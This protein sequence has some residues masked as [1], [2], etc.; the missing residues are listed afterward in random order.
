[1]IV[2]EVCFRVTVP[3]NRYVHVVND[4]PALLT[5]LTCL[6]SEMGYHSTDLAERLALD[7]KE[8][9]QECLGKDLTV[10]FRLPRDIFLNWRGCSSGLF[11]PMV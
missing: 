4:D 9:S 11:V 1:M 7:V 10:E 3:H 6:L 8:L 2:D 5:E